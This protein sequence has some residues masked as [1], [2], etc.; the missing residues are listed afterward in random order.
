[1]KPFN[2]E[3]PEG[4]KGH[5][6]I[7]AMSLGINSAEIAKI[8]CNRYYAT[9]KRHPSEFKWAGFNTWMEALKPRSPIINDLA[10]LIDLENVPRSLFPKKWPTRTAND[11]NDR[12]AHKI[13]LKFV[14]GMVLTAK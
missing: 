8:F 11:L 13:K 1:M 14:M 12:D 9:Q 3:I 4:I 2:G 5:A 6:N 10:R 7:L